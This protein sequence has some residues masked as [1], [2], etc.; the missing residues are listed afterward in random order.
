MIMSIK[1]WCENRKA[2]FWLMA[3][4]AIVFASL[5]NNASATRITYGSYSCSQLST[6][7]HTF[8][9]TFGIIA[10]GLVAGDEVRIT[11]SGSGTDPF[12]AN[13]SRPIPTTFTGV[14]GSGGLSV[15]D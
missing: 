10:T 1:F 11:S 14:I 5:P 8:S 4:L 7:T 12:T 13:G 9:N 3:A 2:T 6:G 15:G